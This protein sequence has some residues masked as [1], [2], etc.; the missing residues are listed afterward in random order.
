[1]KATASDHAEISQWLDKARIVQVV[2]MYFRALDEKHFDES[3]FRQMLAPDAKVIRPNGAAVVGPASIADSHARSF[4]RFEATQHLVT[5]HDVD[6]D[7]HTAAVRANLVAIHIWDDRP[8]EA[9]M[10]ER[11]LT[12]GGVITVGLTR[13]QDGW[14]IIHTENRVIWR[15]G[16]FGDMLQFN[17]QAPTPSPEGTPPVTA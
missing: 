2:N 13:T 12:A 6:V 9:S 3:H 10:L 7:G 17:Y 1:M 4:A 11:S 16:Y 14:R 8:A 5:G 15:L